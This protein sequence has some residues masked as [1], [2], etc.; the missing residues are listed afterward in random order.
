MQPSEVIPSGNI[1]PNSKQ[2]EKKNNGHQHKIKLMSVVLQRSTASA[3]DAEI[4]MEATQ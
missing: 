3:A 2:M 1:P 4:S